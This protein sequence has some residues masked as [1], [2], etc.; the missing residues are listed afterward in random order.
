MGVAAN[1]RTGSKPIALGRVLVKCEPS[2]S[3]TT[4]E[5]R[6]RDV[7]PL[8]K[9]DVVGGASSPDGDC[10]RRSVYLGQFPALA[11][12]A[13]ALTGVRPQSVPTWRPQWPKVREVVGIPEGFMEIDLHTL[14]SRILGS[15]GQDA[16]DAAPLAQGG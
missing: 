4:A 13:E 15:A 12:C 3:P 11:A 1:T 6:S 7:S 9:P 14:V 16:E 8:G 10:S 2:T 5:C